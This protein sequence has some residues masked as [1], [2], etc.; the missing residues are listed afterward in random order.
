MAIIYYILDEQ[1]YVDW[2]FKTSFVSVNHNI[3]AL[4]ALPYY[5]RENQSYVNDFISEAKPY[6]TKIREYVLNY[7]NTEPWDGDV[8]DFDVASY[9][10]TD[11]GLYRKPNT[12][13]ADDLARLQAGINSPYNANKTF[14]VK[15]LVIENA[16]TSYTVPPV[17]T[18][19]GGGGTGAT[20]TAVIDT[21][22][23]TSVTVTNPGTGYTSTPT[24]TF[25]DSAGTTAQAYARLSNEQIR[26]FES[27]LKF[28][29]IKYTSEV[30]EW[31]G[32]TSYNA[33]DKITHLGEAYTANIDFT[34][35]VT[36]TSDNL[37]VIADETFTNAMDRSIAY[38][39]P[40]STQPAKQ[41]ENLFYG[42]EYPRNK[43]IGPTFDQE[44]GYARGGFDSVPFDNFE[45]GPEGIKMISGV[46]DTNITA[47][48]I[49][50]TGAE[51]EAGAFVDF[52]YVESGYTENQTILTEGLTVAQVLENRFGD[53]LLG[54][55]P[56]DIDI[57]G[58]KFVDEYN[59]HSPEEFI[60][61]RVFDSLD[62][63][64]YQTPSSL[65][66]GTALSPKI[67]VVKHRANGTDVRFSFM[68]LDNLYGD[69]IMIYTAQQGK[70]QPDEFTLD[71][72]TFEV[73]FN[74]APSNNDIID[75]INIGTTGQN[76]VLDVV[77][78]S[79]GTDTKITLPVKQDLAKQSLVLVNGVKTNHTIADESERGVLTFNTAPPLGAHIHVFVF[80][81]DESV[82]IAYSHVAQDTFVMNGSLRTFTM[83]NQPFY[84]GPTDAKLFVELNENRLRPAVY[85][86]FTGDGTT[87]TFELTD[88]ADIDHA[89][90]TAS[91]ISIYVNGAANTDWTLDAQVGTDPR[92]VTFNS[93]PTSGSKI[94][95]GDNT[96][97][98][99]TVVGNQLTLD[100]SLPV[101]NGTKLN[102]TTFSNHDTLEITAQTFKG[103][104]ASEVTITIGYDGDSY[105]A[106][107]F[108]SDSIAVI[109]SP[110]F[111]LYRT[112]TDVNYIWVT[113]NGIKLSVSTDYEVSSAGDLVIKK[114]ITT[115]DI[116]VV[117]QFSDKTIKKQIA[118]RMWK[119]VLGVTR[120]TRMIEDATTK[121]AVALNR[122]DSEITV[123]DGTRLA[124]PDLAGNIP[125]VVFIGNERITYWKKDGNVL[126]NLRR[127]T[128]GTAIAF[129]H[130][131]GDLVVDSSL[132]QEIPNP[133]DNVWYNMTSTTDSLQYHTTQQAKFLT[134]YAGTIPIVNIAY[135]QNGRYLNADYVNDNYVQINE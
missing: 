121:I 100:S 5:R 131:V 41:L 72:S 116:I 80:N 34:S 45:V 119:D 46:A 113:L 64:I 130:Y 129:R 40:T 75:I 112:I 66:S 69:N 122:S 48:N 85:S 117:N 101:T 18:I 3:R 91:D 55:R 132:R 61:G 98:E 126:S 22:V 54:T 17:I 19:S 118:W 96:N 128:M 24:V 77:Y 21:G 123:D 14:I 79:N 43:I 86:Y 71:Y 108:D 95:I 106:S 74:T 70:V 120:F 12:N 60:P 83:D 10:D 92:T 16:G 134:E 103:L 20:A 6:H 50:I 84:D 57:I 73:V 89:T 51:L 90:I 13:S 111:D 37:T 1:P 39:Q 63:E 53:S 62:M 127:G 32:E 81:L 35:G 27:T 124:D 26:T 76:M 104:T 68:P 87:T 133:Y 7:D 97:A 2:L 59:S 8:T 65:E 36:F 107:N 125:G 88:N 102:T 30:K 11:L 47:S 94:A 82:E 44:P 31:A 115:N 93:A 28:D 135:N 15:E 23:V 42:I 110:L 4:D 105:D 29:R 25:S 99:Y 9:Y 33:G 56:E 38:Y 67:D 58:G 49:A 109:N 78:I 52:D 114:A